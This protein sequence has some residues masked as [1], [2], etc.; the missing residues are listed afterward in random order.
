MYAQIKKITLFILIAALSACSTTHSQPDKAA[1]KAT[2]IAKIN[3]QLGMAYL[4]R[5]EIQRAKQ[6]LLLALDQD[7]KLPE[8]WYAMGYFMEA[9]GDTENAKSYY[10]KAVKIAPEQGDVQNNYG[11]FLCRHGEY[12]TAI[13]HFMLAVADTNYLDTASA[14]ENAGLCALKIPDKKIALKY[15]NRAIIEDPNHASA[16]LEAALLNYQQHDYQ[17]AKLQLAEYTAV[18]SPTA[19]SIMLSRKLGTMDLPALSMVS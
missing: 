14:Y 18:A 16:I 11:T 9:T 17:Q 2:R 3:T 7:P 10:L 6:K 19:Q 1:I 4:Q 13:K 8:A 12:E 15:F 5:H